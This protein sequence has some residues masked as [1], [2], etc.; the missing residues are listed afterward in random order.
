[1]PNRWRQA[2]RF[3]F[4]MHFRRILISLIISLIPLLKLNGQIRYDT[5]IL[6]TKPCT[7][8]KIT[9]R[10]DTFFKE[11]RNE[12][13]ECTTELEWPV[14]TKCG[15]HQIDSTLNSFI[16]QKLFLETVNQGG[17]TLYEFCDNIRGRVWNTLELKRFDK[18]FLII[19][20]Y[21]KHY[22]KTPGFLNS[23]SIL[24]NYDFN[25]EAF[26]N[27]WGLFKP[28]YNS[29]EIR[30]KIKQLNGIKKERQLLLRPEKFKNLK[31]KIIVYPTPV[32]RMEEIT[33]KKS[34]LKKYLKEEYY[35]K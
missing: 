34:D 18:D 23:G 33:L 11:K 28:N 1:M 29:Q 3:I 17:K 20:Y 27:L 2:K 8:K 15:S 6:K 25:K 24:I 9:M 16:K 19:Y 22:Y 21:F 31:S 7:V 26:I 35:H 30:D 4:I 32:M 5:T 10:F 12:T 13:K 14:F